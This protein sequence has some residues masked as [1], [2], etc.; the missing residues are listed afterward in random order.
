MTCP[1]HPR[2]PVTGTCS[3]C[4]RFVCARCSIELGETLYCR[5]CAPSAREAFARKRR[6][7][8]DGILHRDLGFGGRKKFRDFESARRWARKLGLKSGDE[9]RGFVKRRD[10]P[11]DVPKGPHR[12]PEWKGMG[13]WLRT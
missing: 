8:K 6:P 13:D 5:E 3:D 4:E 10:F 9:W 11:A 12:Y 7:R 1:K 2:S